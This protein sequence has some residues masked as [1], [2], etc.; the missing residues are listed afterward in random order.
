MNEF[1]KT[2]IAVAHRWLLPVINTAI[3]AV[4]LIAA[5]PANADFDAGQQAW[6]A[7][8]VSE[9]VTQWQAAANAGDRRAMLELGRLYDKGLGVIQD[10]VEAHK[11]FNLAAS[12]GDVAALAERDALEAK[13]TPTQ[14]ASAQQQ[15][16]A[17]QSGGDSTPAAATAPPPEAIREAQALLTQLGYAPDSADGIWGD[18][19]ARAYQSFLQD[20]GLPAAD[21]LTPTTLQAMRDMA[22]KA[23]GGQPPSKPARV[24]PAA[25]LQA[26][27]AGNIDAMN[28]A[29]AAGVDVDAR[30]GQGWTALMHAVN[31]GY[32]LLVQPLLDAEADLNIRAPDG[33]TALFMAVVHGHG[34]IIPLLMEAGADPWAKGPKGK[35][36]ADVARLQRNATA[37]RAMGIPQAGDTLRDCP[38]C[39]KMVVVPAGSFMM[40]SPG[41]E[42]GRFDHEGP[43]HQ[44]TIPKPFAVGVYEVTFDEWDAC[45]R[46]GGCTHNPEDDGWGRGSRPVINV[47]W[48]DAQEYVRW[49]S[50]KTGETYR[51]LS[52]SEWEYTAR[53]GTQTRYW[54]GDEIGTNRANCDGCGSRWDDEQ[55]APVGSFSANAF[56]L[57]DV[58]GNVYER[59]GDCWNDSY[60]GAPTDGSV[61]ESG[62][63]G[64]WVLRGGSWLNGPRLLRSADR[65]RDATGGRSTLVGFRV[66]RT[67]GS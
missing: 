12:R 57:Y 49:L 60:R 65:I 53:A 29:L 35:A 43:V 3:L 36:P 7:G 27:Q 26:A 61:W 18:G 1:H 63:C 54:W 47:S 11:W 31:Q 34:E 6:D 46:A 15:A 8:N 52:E 67:I 4:V 41:S 32:I 10:Y 45:R 59:F 9:A 56:G 13:M 37:L 55:T 20:A 64:R 25:L 62:D 23:P 16:A 44:V 19:T 66:A 5:Q 21:T 38:E 28:A 39:P 33:A 22:G 48:D 40:G 42:E 50:Q 2:P 58:H 17:F 14:L 24:S 30:D 51:L